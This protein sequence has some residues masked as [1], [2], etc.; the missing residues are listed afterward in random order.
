MAPWGGLS[1]LQMNFEL[2]A[3][4]VTLFPSSPYALIAIGPTMV[5]GF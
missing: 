1:K 5:T 2:F 4:F 3:E